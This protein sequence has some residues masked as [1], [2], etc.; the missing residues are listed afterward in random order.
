MEC[1]KAHIFFATEYEEPI[2]RKEMRME[3]TSRDVIGVR[4]NYV[5]RD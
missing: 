4:G 5:F 3:C 1:I 2:Q